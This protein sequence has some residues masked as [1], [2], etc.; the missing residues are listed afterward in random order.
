MFFNAVQLHAEMCATLA[1][2][3]NRMHA[4]GP[5]LDSE[6]SRF[7]KAGIQALTTLQFAVDKARSLLQYCADCSK[8]YMVYVAQA[9]LRVFERYLGSLI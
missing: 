5:S 4:I 6:R 3:V 1:A 7:R 9:N 2:L 8:L